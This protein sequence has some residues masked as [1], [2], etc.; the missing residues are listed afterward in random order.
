MVAGSRS[1]EDRLSLARRAL[2]TWM[3]IILAETVHGTLRELF[4]APLL[5]DLRARQFGVL[6]GC[7]LTFG[8]A[9]FLIRWIG[10]RRG[11]PL[12]AIGAVWVLLTLVFEFSVGRA[13]G[14]SWDRILSDYDPS[15]GGFML[16]GL[17]FMLVT[18]WLAARARGLTTGEVP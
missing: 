18:P 13:L 6:V 4:V 9:W 1:L 17:A 16:L 12:L 10:E 8:V 2:L 11:A 7:G 14:A 5:G 15:R 3:L